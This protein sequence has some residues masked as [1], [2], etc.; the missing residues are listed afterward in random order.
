MDKGIGYPQSIVDRWRG[1][2]LRLWRALG[3]FKEAVRWYRAHCPRPLFLP[4]H[5]I[6]WNGFNLRTMMSSFVA[7]ESFLSLIFL[8][9]KQSKSFMQDNESNGPCS[10][11]HCGTPPC[12]IIHNTQITVWLPYHFPLSEEC[13]IS[14]NTVWQ[15][16]SQMY[17]YVTSMWLK[18]I[19][20]PSGNYTSGQNGRST[21]V[22]VLLLPIDR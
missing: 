20:G 19:S 2:V 21:Y 15:Y 12:V 6:Q 8:R 1:S 4:L 22:I 9:Q 3:G 11:Y 14:Y 18:C 7:K 10:S 13:Q 5:K 16:V 17:S